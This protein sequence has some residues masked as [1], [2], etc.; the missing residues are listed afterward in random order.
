MS[1]HQTLR[2]GWTL[3][4]FPGWLANSQGSC[5]TPAFHTSGMP[6]SLGAWNHPNF[7][8]GQLL[9]WFDWDVAQHPNQPDPTLIDIEIII[10]L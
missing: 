7:V 3:A 4:S 6:S 1:L 9:P 5:P 10:Q 8:P 2:I